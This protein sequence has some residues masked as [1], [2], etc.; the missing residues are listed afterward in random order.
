M[1]KKKMATI[2]AIATITAMS[3]TTAF[4]TGLNT[5]SD[6]SKTTKTISNISKVKATKEV[7]ETTTQNKTTEKEVVLAGTMQT[8]EG[9][10]TN[11]NPAS[12]ETKFTYMGNGIYEYTIKNLPAGDYQYKVAINGSWKVNYGAY[13]NENGANMTITNPKTQDVTFWYSDV[14]HITQASLNYKF[15][16]ID[17][18]GT[19]LKGEQKLNGNELNGVYNLTVNLPKGFYDNIY[20]NVGDKEL[21]AEPFV[22]SNQSQP[23]TFTYNENTNTFSNNLEKVTNINTSQIYYNS[24]NSEYKTNFGAIKQGEETTFNIQT[25]NEGVTNANLVMVSPDGQKTNYP[26]KANG[27]F[28]NGSMKWTTN[29]TLNNIG[30]YY[31]Y[32]TVGNNTQTYMY[33]VGQ[34]NGVPTGQ[35]QI[36]NNPEMKYE[37]TVYERDYQTPEWMKH[38]VFYEIFVDRFRYAP[39]PNE[40][41]I[42]DSSQADVNT[43][44]LWFQPDWYKTPINPSIQNQKGYINA[45]AN[46]K[47]W[48]TEIYGG[49]LKGIQEELGYLKSLGVNALYLT[50][51]YQANS[52]HRYDGADYGKVDN[53]VGNN[54]E[55]TEFC[56]V[57]HQMGFHIMLDGAFENAGE[58]SMYF[59][60]W[61]EYLPP[62]GNYE[63]KSGSYGAPIGAYQYWK[64]VYNYMN[65]EHMTEEQAKEATKVYF[66]KNY[67]TNNFEF[68]SWFTVYNQKNP[69]GSYKYDA[70]EGYNSLAAVTG[71]NGQQYKVKSWANYIYK[72][73]DS[74]AEKWINMG[75]NG[76]RLDSA[77][78]ISDQTW[79]QFRKY[80][81]GY[82][83]N[84]VIL[85]EDWTDATK[86]FLGNEFDS[87][88]N[89]R[90][91]GA[92]IDFLKDGWTGSQTNNLL[93]YIHEET[94]NPAFYD[95][96]NLTSSQD[97]VRILSV[98]NGQNNNDKLAT[99]ASKQALA[100]DKLVPF[101]Q[102]TYPGAPSV[103]Y[104][105]EIGMTGAADPNNR[106]GFKWGEG[107]ESVVIDYADL[108]NM[109]DE[110]TVLQTGNISPINVSDGNILAYERFDN[111]NEAVA[112]INR[113]NEATVTLDLNH[114][115]NGTLYDALTGT[116]Y[117]VVN[118]KV[119]VHMNGTSGL[120]LV[121]NYKPLK[122]NTKGLE[123]AYNPKYKIK[124]SET[125]GSVT[126]TENKNGSITFTYFNPNAKSVELQT[127]LTNFK[128]GPQMIKDS[129][130]LWSV[131]IDGPKTSEEIQYKFE[132]DG[133]VWTDGTGGQTVMNGYN[134]NDVI[135]YTEVK[136][137]GTSS[138]K[139]N[140]TTQKNGN[141]TANENKEGK[142]AFT[143][144]D[145]S[146]KSVELQT[147]LTNFKNGPQM[148]KD[149]NGL[150]SVTID[151]PKTSGEIQYK[152][153]VN[154]NDW[155]DGTGVKT[156]MNGN[157]KNDVLNYEVVKVNS[158]TTN[159]TNKKDSSKENS[160][161]KKTS[162]KPNQK[163]TN[164]THKVTPIEE[165]VPVTIE[166]ENSKTG[167]LLKN[168]EVTINGQNMTT[169]NKGEITIKSSLG[170][171]N[172]NISIN[173]YYDFST[174]IV[175]KEKDNNIVVKIEK[176]SE[177]KII[178]NDISNEVHTIISKIKHWFE[179]L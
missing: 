19:G 127:S 167:E 171:E 32:F 116:K 179:E 63:I 172:I 161:T 15:L 85:G 71:L 28:G 66:E 51:L 6:S 159:T 99:P 54:K 143:Y 68:A 20:I 69:D 75:S 53:I 106:E 81:K 83:P 101:I 23:V 174:Q 41:K 17:L 114:M 11:W 47:V 156:I 67:D 88:M 10:K 96:L 110:Y 109:R 107:N 150:W 25:P 35:G 30:M 87:V 49:N 38:A 112:V 163:N 141:V 42:V 104:G 97:T 148:T 82:D 36:T 45:P 86:Y 115:K 80:V 102:M 147:S 137:E 131:T 9:S 44:H 151:G 152:F 155:T 140:T 122:V 70:W 72:N 24:R 169:N 118:G 31:Y 62:K 61:G 58:N 3:S 162:T 34:E 60:R 138:K 50:P 135:N 12:N 164:S 103:Y 91:R 55:F 43:Q 170:A 76:W 89:Y 166:V 158:E 94:P 59:D 145:P 129:N 121:K 177:F 154:G 149:S 125:S 146:A 124:T 40:K 48:N 78:S 90:F 77:P 1:I 52:T 64:T 92:V 26:M 130:G 2:I 57:A 79:Q 8:L 39:N 22:V 136:G 132:V 74:I 120:V 128:N 21:K 144:F 13:G 98:L 134:Q 157:N 178:E 14:S 73:K 7:Q 65:N 33:S 16:N 93:Q 113:G 56:N 100:L 111:S 133:N 117:N 105:D 5:K 108:M 27:T 4:A 173:D 142:I 18:M 119:I 139:D 37:L 165:K 176:E 46:E 29:V 95:L 126:A 160:G 168:T 123:P 84:S 175:V 153:E